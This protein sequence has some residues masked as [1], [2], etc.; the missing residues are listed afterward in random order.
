MTYFMPR[1]HDNINRYIGSIA[2]AT[3]HISSIE[4]NATGTK[5]ATV[6]IR[7]NDM[8]IRDLYVFI[9]FIY[10]LSLFGCII[11][12]FLL[13]KQSCLKFIIWRFF[14]RLESSWQSVMRTSRQDI[15]QNLQ[16][17]DNGC[18]GR[19]RRLSPMLYVCHTWCVSDWRTAPYAREA[20]SRSPCQWYMA[21][22]VGRTP[23]TAVVADNVT[24]AFHIQRRIPNVLTSCSLPA[25]ASLFP[26]R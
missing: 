17:C 6:T 3:C 1:K 26:Y 8:L 13:N 12:P 11:T 20:A 10:L 25:S 16:Y 24:V 21:K 7:S 4:T 9:V 2:T 5:Q 19:L 18:C 15:P 23:R 22:T 14:D